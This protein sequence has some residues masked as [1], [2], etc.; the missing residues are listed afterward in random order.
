M[1]TGANGAIFNIVILAF[2]EPESPFR[3]GSG[4]TGNVRPSWG[5]A[6][7]TPPFPLVVI[8]RGSRWGLWIFV[9]QSPQASG[10]R[11]VGGVASGPSVSISA[12]ARNSGTPACG[13]TAAWSVEASSPSAIS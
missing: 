5:R 12:R 9:H 4:Q 10:E 13:N 3:P 7:A 11:P 1:I 6:T 8:E 2:L